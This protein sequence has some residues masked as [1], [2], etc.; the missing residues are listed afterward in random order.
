M[1]HLYTPIPN[2]GH[3]GPASEVR[4]ERQSW[5]SGVILRWQQEGFKLARN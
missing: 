5:E 2:Q 4:L 1:P 3:H